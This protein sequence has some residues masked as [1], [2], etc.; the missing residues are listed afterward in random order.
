MTQ[1]NL[2]DWTPPAVVV[3]FP[4]HKRGAMLQEIAVTFIHDGYDAGNRLAVRRGCELIAEHWRAGFRD[5]DEIGRQLELFIAAW[6]CATIPRM[7]AAE[8]GPRPAT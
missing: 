5:Q 8:E 3:P 6:R 7:V 2:F 4:Y 1:L